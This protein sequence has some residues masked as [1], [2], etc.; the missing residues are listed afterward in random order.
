[1]AA[2]PDL[3]PILDRLSIREPVVGFYDAPDPIPFAPLVEPG[4]SACV[5]AAFQS[6]GQGR[7]LHLTKDR[8]GCGAPHLLGIDVRSR[9]EMVDF[10]WGEEGL[11]ATP[12]L[13][14]EWL[15]LETRYHPVHDHLLIGPLRPD[16][17]Q[18]LRTATFYVNPD[19][20]S[21]LAV[22]ATYYHRPGDPSPLIS[23]FGS[24]CM[25]LVTLFD[26]LDIPQALIGS[27]DHA[28][29]GYLEPWMLAFTVTKPMLELLARWAA[30]RRSSLHA[31]FLD[32]LIRER[33][34]SLDC[35][36][37]GTAPAGAS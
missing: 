33:G 29:R 5:F 18:Y 30:D 16:Q 22:G 23:R 15:D 28:A 4:G 12:E 7:T 2:Q 20:L 25:Q 31:R 14:A 27:T 17:Y 1:M 36:G 35:A 3:S 13:M 21:V 9:E 19:Q 37:G 10:L 32:S 6:W 34:G 8:H 11:R 26:S 24:G